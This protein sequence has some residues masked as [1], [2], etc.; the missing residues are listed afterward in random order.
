MQH[1][2]RTIRPSSC[3]NNM[4]TR[5]RQE[6]IATWTKLP[7]L[8]FYV[9]LN[10]GE[11]FNCKTKR[12]SLVLTLQCDRLIYRVKFELHTKI[13]TTTFNYTIKGSDYRKSG[14]DR[15]WSRTI[16]SPRSPWST[17]TNC[18][19]WGT[20]WAHDRAYGVRQQQHSHLLLM[21]NG[22]TAEVHRWLRASEG[23]PEPLEGWQRRGPCNWNTPRRERWKRC[24][25]G[26]NLGCK[27]RGASHPA[28]R[29]DGRWPPVV[30]VGDRPTRSRRSSEPTR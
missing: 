6:T 5:R 25:K 13:T 7:F 20:W 10:A 30:P 3:G 22:Y 15:C 17:W 14:C 2:S 19:R 29:Q 18:R 28:G 27:Q 24:R 9:T 21:S 1:R 23:S 11:P 26:R 8:W 12:I 4:Y 16:W